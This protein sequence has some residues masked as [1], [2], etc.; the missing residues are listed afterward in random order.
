MGLNISVHTEGITKARGIIRRSVLPPLRAAQHRACQHPANASPMPSP[1]SR[2][3]GTRG[4][5]SRGGL[6]TA[7]YWASAGAHITAPW[8]L[9][10]FRILRPQHLPNSPKIFSVLSYLLQWHLLATARAKAD[11]LLL[12]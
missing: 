2:H 8:D 7:A 1:C 9:L 5:G 12:G 3:K 6:P 10:S 4:T 11:L